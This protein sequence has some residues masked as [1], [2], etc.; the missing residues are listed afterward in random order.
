[1]NRLLESRKALH[2]TQRQMA[3]ILS[4]RQNAYSMIE[5]GKTNL[6]ERN[7]STL[8][9][10]L[11]INPSWLTEGIGPMFD[12]TPK[13]RTV[14]HGVPYYN[15]PIADYAQFSNSGHTDTELYFDGTPE[16]DIDYPPFNDCTFYR[17]VVGESMSSRFCTSDV[18]ACKKIADPTVIMFGETYL[19]VIT[20]G[21]VSY[22]IIRI[23]RKH[24]DPN[25]IILKPQNSLFDDITIRKESIK[26]L[27][28][29]KGKISRGI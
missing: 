18:V 24:D 15:V 3:D 1:M 8:A 9:E 14:R 26:E 17:P 23:I 20:E 25:Q 29:I 12:V 16:Y 19:C 2:L 5:T 27:Y 22:E 10:K 4:I 6:T 21:T 28:I 11:H 7:K 13:A